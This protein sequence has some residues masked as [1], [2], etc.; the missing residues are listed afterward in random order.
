[1]AGG[2]TLHSPAGRRRFDNIGFSGDIANIPLPSAGRSVD[3]WFNTEAGFVRTA[4]ASSLTCAPSRRASA[5]SRVALNNQPVTINT[6]INERASLQP[7]G[8]FLNAM[9]RAWFANLNTDPVSSLFGA[10]TSE[11]ATCAACSSA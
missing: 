11:Q 2:R 7:R 5:D 9:N 6:R 3:R 1:M 10:I 4:Q 8:E